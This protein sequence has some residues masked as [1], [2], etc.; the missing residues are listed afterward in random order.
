MKRLPK[1]NVMI[2]ML[3]NLDERFTEKIQAS[4]INGLLRAWPDESEVHGL[5]EEY[6]ANSTETWDFAED[7]VI[8]LREIR[9]LKTK[10]EVIRFCIDFAEQEE[11]YLEPLEKFEAAFNELG[12]CKIL[13]ESLSVILCLGNI[14]NGGNKTKGQA[15]GFAIEGI[16]KIIT[17]KDVNNKSG[18]EYICKKIHETNP[19]LRDFKKHLRGFYGAKRNNLTEL[20]TMFEGFISQTGGVKNKCELITNDK[21]DPA[22]ETY[23][24]SVKKKIDSFDEK[25]LEMKGRYEECER[26]WKKMGEYY[27]MRKDD[28]KMEDTSK[29]FTFWI[30]YFDALDKHWPKE[31]KVKAVANNLSSSRKKE[32]KLPTQGM[33]MLPLE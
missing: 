15:D 32:S 31:K 10:C 6:V 29:F 24:A 28:E 25:L 12:E 9:K 3:S 27:G 26:K 4:V 2:E 20:K 33:R 18:M 8:N 1:P 17:I 30:Q 5:M 23:E 13:K 22:A 16:T 11:F 21:E 7:Y 14:L 19:D